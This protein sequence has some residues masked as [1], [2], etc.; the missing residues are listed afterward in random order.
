MNRSELMSVLFARPP[1]KS[2]SLSPSQRQQLNYLSELYNLQEGLAE[3]GYVLPES[4][5]PQPQKPSS[6]T[7]QV[8]DQRQS[9]VPDAV[10][11]ARLAREVSSHVAL[12]E[13]VKQDIL[14]TM[15]SP[16]TVRG[17]TPSPPGTVSTGGS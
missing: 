11:S 6:D 7:N 3:S 12:M 2:R 16:G 15:P 9:T 5:T 13:S 4:T 17:L 8:A 14:T 1:W 10:A